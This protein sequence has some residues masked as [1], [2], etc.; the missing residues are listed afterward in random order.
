A[1]IARGLKDG[2]F[3]A[4]DVEGGAGEDLL[5]SLLAT[6]AEEGA[7]DVHVEPTDDG[8]EIRFRRDG[9][10]HVHRTLSHAEAGVLSVLTKR[11]ANLDASVSGRPQAGS[12]TNEGARIR[13]SVCPYVRGEGIAFRTSWP[14]GEGGVDSLELG[15]ERSAE[16]KSWLAAGRG[17]ILVGSPPSGGRVQTIE[18]LLA[19]LDRDRR[20]VI[21]VQQGERI[22]LPGL[23]S[24]RL[25]PERGLDATAALRASMVQD[26]DVVGFVEPA[27]ADVS[28]LAIGAALSGHL[29]ILAMDARGASEALSTF[30]RL[31]PNPECLA[32]ALLGVVAV[33]RLPRADGTGTACVHQI[34]GAGAELRAS[35]RERSVTLPEAAVTLRTEAE[36]LAGEGVVAA[37]AVERAFG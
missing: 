13:V 36:R 5:T 22:R 3:E 29:V 1:A 26:L 15:G 10:L 32:E 9:D 8:A 31:I 30:S 17:V 25:D 11:A 16:V 21:V 14:T 6:A 20:K 28:G 34:A 37:D 24:I 7:S 12:L 2:T 33:R 27:G 4:G 23:L 18:A 19:T 35:L